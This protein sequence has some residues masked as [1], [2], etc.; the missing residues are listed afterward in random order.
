M[1]TLL[2]PRNFNSVAFATEVGYPPD[3]Q[4]NVIVNCPDDLTEDTLRTFCYPNSPNWK[5]L[6]SSLYNSPEWYRVKNS[7][8]EAATITNELWHQLWNYD[9]FPELGAE[10]LATIAALKA[11]ANPTIAEKTAI[12]QIMRDCNVPDLIIQAV[13][14]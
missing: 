14:A 13:E 7:S 11:V 12:A 1:I 8:I 5:L 9:R 6:R 2:V 4:S 3:I 10:I